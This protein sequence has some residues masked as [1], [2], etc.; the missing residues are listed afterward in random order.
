MMQYR[1]CICGKEGEGYGHSCWPIYP[2]SLEY[3]CCDNC[4]KYVIV[5]ERIRDIPKYSKEHPDFKSEN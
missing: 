4:N 1:C 3:R 5:P 2:D